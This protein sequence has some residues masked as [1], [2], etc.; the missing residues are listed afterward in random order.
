MFREGCAIGGECAIISENT[1]IYTGPRLALTLRISTL[2]KMRNKIESF[3]YFAKGF[4]GKN[5][6]SCLKNKKEFLYIKDVV[7][8]NPL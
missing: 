3:A 6:W 5:K 4:S 7:G 8:I 1:V 2:K